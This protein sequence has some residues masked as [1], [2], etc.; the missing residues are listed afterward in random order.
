MNTSRGPLVEV[1]GL[2][3]CMALADGIDY[4]IKLK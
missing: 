1:N 3:F 2:A 4:L